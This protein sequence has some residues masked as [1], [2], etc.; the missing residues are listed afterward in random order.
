MSK[1]DIVIVSMYKMS[2]SSGSAAANTTIVVF[3]CMSFLLSE[4]NWLSS[5][6]K[7]KT[8]FTQCPH[9][10]G[11]Y[12]LIAESREKIATLKSLCFSCIQRNNFIFMKCTDANVNVTLKGN[13]VFCL[14]KPNMLGW[15][16]MSFVS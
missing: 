16:I 3:Y 7:I 4:E 10:T 11:G 15:R 5:G 6:I 9:L 13:L 8:E 14:L 1:S 2:L 12:M